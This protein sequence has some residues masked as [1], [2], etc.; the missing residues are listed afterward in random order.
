[1]SSPF[2]LFFSLVAAEKLP[3]AERAVAVILAGAAEGAVIYNVDFKDASDALNRLVYDARCALLD[4][5]SPK[6]GNEREPTDLLKFSWD[7]NPSSLHDIFA[8]HKK[9][10]ATKLSG[11]F[12]DATRAFTAELLPLAEASKVCRLKVVKGRKPSCAPAKPVNPDK[13]V[14]TCPCC[15][16]A[17]AV[18]EDR[19]IVLHGYERPGRGFLRGKCFGVNF[20]ALEE[21]TVGLEAYIADRAAAAESLQKQLAGLDARNEHTYLKW[22]KG[23]RQELVTVKRGEADFAAVAAKIKEENSWGLRSVESHL[24]LLRAK[25]AERTAAKA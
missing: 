18:G 2:P 8:A 19:K 25:L 24:R 22:V 1:M 11:A 13:V 23:G 9:A 10:H 5:I 21:S 17:I 7:M 6:C 14:K 20:P 15:F 16:R 4:G 12:V 3:R